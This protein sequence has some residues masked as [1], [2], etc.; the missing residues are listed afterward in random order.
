MATTHSNTAA[1]YSQPARSTSGVTAASTHHA[2][3][4]PQTR[5]IMWV[6]IGAL[7][8]AAIIWAVTRDDGQGTTNQMDRRSSEQLAPAP[9]G[10]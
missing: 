4:K 8:L 5:T 9:A 1:G 2:D 6:V 10:N 3:D 7:V